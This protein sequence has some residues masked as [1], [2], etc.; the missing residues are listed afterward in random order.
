MYL[1]VSINP[2]KDSQSFIDTIISSIEDDSQSNSLF[3]TWKIATFQKKIDKIQDRMSNYK[4][5]QQ[6][7]S[8]LENIGTLYPYPL[9]KEKIRFDFIKAVNMK[10][11][12]DQ[13]AM[14]FARCIA[15]LRNHFGNDIKSIDLLGL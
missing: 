6:K 7:D 4:A 1:V 9:E 2:D 12:A 11:E 8:Q 10:P 5:L 13:M 3:K 14:Y 15:M